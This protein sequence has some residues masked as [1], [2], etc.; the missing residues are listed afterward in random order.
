MDD[1]RHKSQIEETGPTLLELLLRLEGNF[2]RSS[3]LIR[4]TPSQSG[5]IL[6]AG[7]RT[8]P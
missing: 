3:G 7:A 8:N 2:Q 4:V 5:M 1:A 6:H